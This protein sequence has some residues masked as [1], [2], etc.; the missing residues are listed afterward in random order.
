MKV[1]KTDMIN[2]PLAG[3]ILWFALP[4]AAGSIL[5][6]FFNAADLAV[7]SH[8]AGGGALAAVGSNTS[9]IN[10]IVNLFT[11]I[12]VGANVLLARSFGKG[13]KDTIRRGVIT[14]V[15]TAIIAGICMGVLGFI[16]AGKIHAAMSTPADVFDDAVLYLRIYFLGIPFIF[17][18]NFCAAIL[19]SK[20]DSRRP[21]LYLSIAG[22][23]NV[24]LNIVFVAGFKMTV[25][26]VAAATAISNVFSSIA[27]LIVLVNEED[28]LKLDFKKLKIEFSVLKDIIKTGLPAGVQGML[29]SMSNII[30]QSNLNKLGSVYVSGNTAQLNFDNIIVFILMAFGSASVTF[31][32]QNIGAGKLDRCK[33]VVI[34]SAVLSCSIGA[35]L[36]IIFYIFRM[37]LLSIFSDDLEIISIALRRMAVAMPFIYISGIQEACAGGLRGLGHSMLPMIVTLVFMV[38]TRFFWML[39]VYPQNPTYENIVVVFPI[40]WILCA[41]VDLIAYIIV[42]RKRIQNT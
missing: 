23:I 30:I 1:Q 8:Y 34:N 17:I 9:I 32:G 39:V 29:V 6:Q 33:R 2:G 4:I 31:T 20:G 7:V 42:Y 22:A 26:G 41:V 16:F 40:A 24:I 10:M 11:G 19:R 18:Y 15:T 36:A 3:K 21:L 37:P 12:S 38:G 28:P 25:N 14:A 27:L 13:D 5:Q 35:C